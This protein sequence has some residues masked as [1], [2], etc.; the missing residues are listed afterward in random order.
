LLNS[1]LRKSFLRSN[2]VFLCFYFGLSLD[3]LSFPAFSLGNSLVNYKAFVEGRSFLF[4]SLVFDNVSL[5]FKF[6]NFNFSI[7]D[8]CFIFVGSS[9][10][11]RAD[12]DFFFRSIGFFVAKH[13]HLF[14]FNLNIVSNHLGRISS[15]EIGSLP[16][17][18]SS[19]FSLQKRKGFSFLYFLG[20]DEFFNISNLINM[21]FFS[22]Y[23][24]SFFNPNA[25]FNSIHLIFPVS[26]YTERVSSFFKY[27]GS[28]T[29]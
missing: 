14:H 29:S 10:L 18:N 20:T 27:R 16:G 7:Y 25:F 17:V 19:N 1:R 13:L 2:G 5:F 28:F 12:C 24:G 26:I 15:F 23:Q 8:S 3:Y 11:N 6:L 4:S 22:V 21:T 9:I